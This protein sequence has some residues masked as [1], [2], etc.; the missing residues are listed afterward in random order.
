MNFRFR[1]ISA[2]ALIL[3]WLFAQN[4]L[5]AHEYS[6]EHLSQTDSHICLAQINDN[7]D[8]MVGI[9]PIQQAVKASYFVSFQSV[10][11][12]PYQVSFGFQA[13]APPIS[14]V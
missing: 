8:L 5:L 7:D 6:S 13:R 9:A 14:L 3:S 4:I 11:Y 1:Q 2:L 12:I 10:G